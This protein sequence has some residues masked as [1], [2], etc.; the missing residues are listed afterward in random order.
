MAT[1]P[2]TRNSLIL[3]LRDR[4]NAEAWREFVGIYEPLIYRIGRRRG[5]Q[6]ADAAELVQ[7]VMLAVTRAVDRWEPDP[8]KGRFRTWLFRIAHNEI[9]KQLSARRVPGT[10]DS[11]IHTLLQ[12]QPS[13][14]ESA[15]ELALE[16]HRSVFRWAAQQIERQVQP[17]T[18]LAFWRTAV[19]GQPVESV[20]RELE[21]SK[22]A[23]YVAR[24]RVMARLR[25]VVQRYEEEIS[26]DGCPQ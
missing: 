2:E 7:R 4:Q 9:C 15:Q 20:A 23:V 21:L 5:L 26:S 3:R 12:R 11:R 10:G 16:Y 8:A 13:P 6:H 19:D 25:T 24:S 22:G 14:D 17:R 1:T 18:W